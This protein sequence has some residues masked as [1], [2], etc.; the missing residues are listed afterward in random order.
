MPHAKH[1][2]YHFKKGQSGNPAG[3]P[4]GTK[5]RVST[6]V[7]QAYL[8]L[9]VSNLPNIELWLERV[10]QRSPEKALEFIVKLSPFVIPKKLDVEID[11]ITP[12]TIVIPN[13]N[14]TNDTNDTDEIQCFTSLSE[15]IFE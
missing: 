15:S 10:A 9:I 4:K 3:R 14:D 6:D 7:R 2:N 12:V 5:N 11:T 8:D 13:L 1:N